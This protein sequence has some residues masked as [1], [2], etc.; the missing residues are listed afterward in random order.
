M[1]WRG[2]RASMTARV[3]GTSRVATRR[4]SATVTGSVPASTRRRRTGTAPVS[5]R[6]IPSG[7]RKAAGALNWSWWRLRRRV[8]RALT[9]R[10]GR[11]RRRGRCAGTTSPP[12][13]GWT[14][15][16]TTDRSRYGSVS[17]IHRWSTGWPCW[18]PD[19]QARRT[20]RDHWRKRC[21]PAAQGA[22]R[23]SSVM[24]QTARTW[25]AAAG[26]RSSA[27]NSRTCSPQDAP[28]PPAP[29]GGAHE[30]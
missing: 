11:A 23:G 5:P 6:T 9:R 2:V 18:R 1:V 26:S 24:L 10:R 4:S 29:A 7:L 12:P 13:G 28:L 15:T 8:G 30:Q 20:T 14:T 25:L 27:A 22:G 16:T 3:S 17:T 19:P 21:T